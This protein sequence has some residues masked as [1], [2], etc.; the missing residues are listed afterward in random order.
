[1]YELESPFKNRHSVLEVIAE[2]VSMVNFQVDLGLF[3]MG[4]ERDGE[5]MSIE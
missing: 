2:G 3:P 1:M 5:G 4:D